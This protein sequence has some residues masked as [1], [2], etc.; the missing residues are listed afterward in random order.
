MSTMEAREHGAH[1]EARGEGQGSRE[2]EG[3]EVLLH[4]AAAD[5]AS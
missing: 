3:R 4:G 5:P 1:K 2:V